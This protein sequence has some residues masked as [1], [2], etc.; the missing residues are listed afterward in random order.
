MIFLNVYTNVLYSTYSP[1]LS[2]N[3]FY[4]SGKRS[5]TALHSFLLRWCKEAVSAVLIMSSNSNCIPW[6]CSKQVQT[7]SNHMEW[8]VESRMCQDLPAPMLQ[9]ILHTT[10]AMRRWIVLEQYDTMFKQFSLIKAHSWPH[11]IQQECTVILANAYH[12]N[13]H[14]M[15]KHESILAEEQDMHGFQSTLTA[16]YNFRPQW[17]LGAPFSILLFQL[18][19]QWMHPWLSNS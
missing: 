9:Q 17:H 19:V 2:T 6:R 4:L 3:F 5:I 16:P 14:G 10:M 8:D 11:L 13:W 1:A 15:I 18:T 7:I 12:T